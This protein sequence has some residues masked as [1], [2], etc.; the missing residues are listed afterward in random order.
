MEDSQAWFAY[1][2]V[3]GKLEVFTVDML[4]LSLLGRRWV[5]IDGDDHFPLCIELVVDSQGK[6]HVGNSWEMNL[7]TLVPFCILRP[8]NP[9]SSAPFLYNICKLPY[10]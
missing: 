7:Q 2:M 5:A 4:P 1:S 9:E 3:V 6:I 10:L 8:G